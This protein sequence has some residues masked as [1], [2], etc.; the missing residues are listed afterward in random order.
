M[1]RIQDY[2]EAR[3]GPETVSKS[4]RNYHIGRIGIIHEI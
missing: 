1:I 2:L 3:T 4:W